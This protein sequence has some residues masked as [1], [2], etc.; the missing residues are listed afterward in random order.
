[1]EPPDLGTMPERSTYAV[2]ADRGSLRGQL[3]VPEYYCFEIM[4]ALDIE[5]DDQMN[6]VQFF[7]DWS[8]RYAIN[9]E[10]YVPGEVLSSGS[11]DNSIGVKW[12]VTSAD[13][14]CSTWWTNFQ[15]NQCSL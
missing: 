10:R 14:A 11:L 2:S 12:K 15:Q 7:I 1:M 4:K 6:F 8:K 5:A 3:T 9:L 13:A